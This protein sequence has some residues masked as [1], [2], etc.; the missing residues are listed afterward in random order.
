MLTLIRLPFKK[1]RWRGFSLQ[2]FLIIILP[3][4][5]LLLVVAFGSQTL[6]HEAMRSLVGDRDLRA[7]QEAAGS[8]GSELAHRSATL[9]LAARSLDG[10]R[11]GVA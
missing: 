11:C 10:R 6:H 7:V 1:A 8:L 4:T 9:Q 3:L 2:L 5:L